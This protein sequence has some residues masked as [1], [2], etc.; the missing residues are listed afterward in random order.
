L[1][2]GFET[3]GHRRQLL[4]AIAKLRDDAGSLRPV[5]LAIDNRGDAKVL[6]IVGR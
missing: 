2:S 6:K 4:V 1:F 3:F 5:K